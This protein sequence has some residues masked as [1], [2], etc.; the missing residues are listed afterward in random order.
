MNLKNNKNHGEISTVMPFYKFKLVNAK[1]LLYFF[2][3][4]ELFFFF[5]LIKSQEK[6]LLLV[7]ICY[8]SNNLFE[9]S[10]MFFRGRLRSMQF[11]T[12]YPLNT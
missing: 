7:K 8:E 3:Q 2:D 6:N 5:F 11:H 1:F 9:K 12:K 10:S 4:N